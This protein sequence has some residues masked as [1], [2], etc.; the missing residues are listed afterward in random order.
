MSVPFVRG[1]YGGFKLPEI[2]MRPRILIVVIMGALLASSHAPAATASPDCT[3]NQCVYLPF[4]AW[5]LPPGI[6]NANFELGRNGDWIESS[7]DGRALITTDYVPG[8]PPHSGAWIARL[9]GHINEVS[10]ISQTIALPDV[11]PGY[12]LSLVYWYHREGH[13]P[14]C[15]ADPPD[16]GFVLIQTTDDAAG[17][18]YDLCSQTDVPAWGRSFFD[19]TRFAGQIASLQV[20]AENVGADA[21]EFY[22]DDLYFVTYCQDPGC[23]PPP[24]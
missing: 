4:V 12:Y 22:V 15:D 3:G 10:V 1:Y 21:G 20:G 14:A 16:D 9:G 17:N 7:S 13:I 19:V 2:V 18:G 11:Q 6:R 5:E 24:E 8:L 23:P